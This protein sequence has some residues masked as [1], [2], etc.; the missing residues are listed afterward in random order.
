MN[1][2]AA[3]LWS[4]LVTAA[5]LALAACSGASNGIGG[6]GNQTCSNIPCGANGATYSQCSTPSS[7]GCAD[8]QYS[9]NGQTT[10]CNTCAGCTQAIQTVIAACMSEPL[11]GGGSDAG[12]GNCSA[13]VPCG[14]GGRTYQECTTVSTG[15]ACESLDYRTSDGHNFTCPGCQ[16]CGAVAQNLQTYCASPPDDGG[17]GNTSCSPAVSCGNTGTTYEECTTTGS[18]GA[19]TSI[20]YKISNGLSYKCASCGDCST[21]LQSLDAYCAGTVQPTTSCTA[22]QLCSPSQTLLYQQCTTSLGGA[23]QDI[24]YET[25]DSQMFTCNSCSDCSSALSNLE[26][27]CGSTTPVTTCGSPAQC[28][29]GSVTYELC[30]TSSGQTCTSEYYSTSDGNT[31]TCTG[32]DCTNAATQLSNYCA[33]LGTTSNC[34]PSCAAGDLCCFCSGTT[35]ECLSSSGGAFDCATYGCQ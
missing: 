15:G 35:Y 1:L 19:C 14:S 4:T 9:A 16:N 34:S 18:G 22:S 2:S 6:S 33:S 5:C 26:S 10:S 11:D 20:N 25:S 3:S 13:A 32:C 28:G 12:N 31:F 27:Y 24:Y 8:V 17:S 7:G 30:T 21:A 23:C 29:S